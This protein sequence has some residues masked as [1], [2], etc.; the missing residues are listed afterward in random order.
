MPPGHRTPQPALLFRTLAV[1]AA[2]AC[3][4]LRAPADSSAKET[5][6]T[7]AH[8]ALTSKNVKIDFGG[9]A[10]R[11]IHADLDNWQLTA[12]DANPGMVRMFFDRDRTPRRDLMPWAGEFAGKFLT[13]AV[14]NYRITHDKRLAHTIENLIDQLKAAQGTDGYLGPH[15]R[16]QRFNG[17]V[18]N[19]ST[20]WDTWGH[21]H[22]MVGLLLWHDES[23]SAVALEVAKN[24]ADCI[25]D[26]FLGAKDKISS[27]DAVEMNQAIVHGMCLLYEH[28]GEK[29]YLRMAE[30]VVK[31]FA[32]PGAGD[33]FKAALAGREFYAMPKPR[34]ESLHAIQ[35]LAELYYIT[36]DSD[37]RKAFEHIWWS[38]AKGDVHNTGGFSS[39]EQAT[40]NPYDPGPIETCCTVAWM[41]LSVDMLRLTGDSVVADE[42]ELATF[43][44]ALGAQSPSG[45]WWTY[46]TPMDGTRNASTHDIAF[47]ARPGAPEL[48]CC[49]VNGPRTLGMMSQ[50]AV[51]TSNDGI[52]VNYY[53]PC[54]AAA[55]TPGGGTVRLAQETG[56]PRDPSVR[57]KVSPSAAER[58]TIHLRIPAW[59]TK[60]QVSVNGKVRT[61]VKPGAYY[62]ISREWKPGDTI[63]TKFDF[64]PRFLA[65][66]KQCEG[67]V[68]IYHGP[69]LLAFDPAFNSL[70]T[71]AVPTID[72]GTLRL[73]PAHGITKPWMAF[74]A[75]VD[76]RTIRL[77]DFA[78][79][80]WS[81]APYRTW[82]PCAS[83]KPLEFTRVNP[84]RT[85]QPEQ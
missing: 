59:S 83:A 78:S 50:W 41:A 24:M 29:R 27:V 30:E 3:L 17:K 58:F 56:Y 38:I 47:Q 75:E 10:G 81:G 4:P 70:D 23:G 11:R 39:G 53:G 22:I 57:I 18:V 84:F 7:K 13:A 66:E 2:L 64:R 85:Y 26:R 1:I 16:D 73:V 61:G 25:C 37:Y 28:T 51:L 46:N 54:Q 67:K 32:S 45:R 68:S 69:V 36:G 52:R 76:K 19:G 55:P 42:L 77:T 6:L 21:Y 48:N 9:M 12:V 82:L 8:P 40:G 14:L 72:V 80:G 15:P 74:D 33:Y 79:S 20:V 43:N 65:G 62:A 71:D 35:G 31:D 5:T 63:E 60:T 34:W 49:S 44:A